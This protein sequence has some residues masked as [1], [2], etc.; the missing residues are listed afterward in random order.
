MMLIETKTPAR[1]LVL[2]ILREQPDQKFSIL[3]VKHELYKKHGKSYSH[4]H[5][6]S[7]LFHLHAEEFVEYEDRGRKGMLFWLRTE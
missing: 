6:K 1:D 7:L 4:S 5:V 2:N 3:H